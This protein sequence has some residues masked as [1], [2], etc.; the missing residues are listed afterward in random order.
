MSLRRSFP[1]LTVTR[2]AVVLSSLAACCVWIAG[3]GVQ[4]YEQRLNNANEMFAYQNRLDRILS[5]SAWADPYGFGVTMRM[6]SGYTQIPAPA[7]PEE[8]DESAEPIADPRQPTYLGITELE[9]LLGA[10]K[11]QADGASGANAFLYL[12]SN[13]QRMLAAGPGEQD[14]PADQFLQDLESLLDLQLGIAVEDG[15]QARSQENVK[16]SE[17]LPRDDAIAKYARRKEFVSM[18][19][20]PSGDALQQLGLPEL[21]IYVYEHRAGS[22]QIALL[23]VAPLSVRDNPD[24]NLRVALETLTVSDQAPRAA[25][26]GES[27]AAPRTGGF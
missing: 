9:G 23:L 2:N 18:Q 17:S 5:K 22:I 10:W 13:H 25:A 24:A 16:V 20:V 4:A 27:G 21:E 14:L 8:G 6:P 11:L 3:C 7:P 1:T 26:P 12:V 19:L 15:G